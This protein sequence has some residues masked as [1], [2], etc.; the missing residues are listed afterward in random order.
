MCIGFDYCIVGSLLYLGISCQVYVMEQVLESLFGMQVICFIVVF[1]D[2]L[3]C[4]WVVC[5]L[6]GC[7]CI[8]MYQL[9]QCLC[10]EVGFF[11]CV[12][13]EQDIDLYISIFNMGLLLLLC[14]LGVCY[15]LL[16]YDLFQIILKN[17]YVNCFK[18]LVYW[19]SD[20]LLIVYVLCVVDC[21][22]IFLQYSVDEVVW[23]FFGVVGKVWVLFNQV[24]GFVGEFVDF[25]VCGL[26]LCYWLLVGICELCKNVFWFVSV[27]IWVCIQV[28]G[29]LLLVLVGSFDYLFEE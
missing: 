26:L 24:D 28:F 18:V 17:Y 7:L 11:L 13:C 16:I 2:D 29:V 8:V 9:Y 22:W 4:Q 20:Y 3:L 25:L 27:W 21:V 14:L 19:V 6:W 23:L 15:V 12:L 1:F 10:F 5:L